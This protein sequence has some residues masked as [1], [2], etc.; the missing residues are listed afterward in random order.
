MRPV[1]RCFH[2]KKSWESTLRQPA[3]KETCEGCGSYLHCCKNCRFHRTG[4]PN[5]CYIPETDKIASK[6]LSNFCDEFEFVSE[7][8][9]ADRSRQTHESAAKL[10]D[11]FGDAADETRN[12][13]HV[14]DWLES[15]DKPKQDL[16]DLFGD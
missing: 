1:Y 16:D 10:E 13:A 6:S 4:Y 3:V 9:L 7:D 5:E 14:K 2:C 11:L 8:S 15:T 12:D